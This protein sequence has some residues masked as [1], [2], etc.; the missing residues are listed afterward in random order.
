MRKLATSNLA[1][2]EICYKNLQRFCNINEAGNS[3][4]DKVVGL[5]ILKSLSLDGIAKSNRS[6]SLEKWWPVS[7]GTKV[8]FKISLIR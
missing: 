1:V 8:V 7:A 2:V 6:N 5:V 3:A 4:A